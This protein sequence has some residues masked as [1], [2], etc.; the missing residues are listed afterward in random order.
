MAPLNSPHRKSYGSRIVAENNEN[1]VP[2]TLWRCPVNALYYTET[3]L[4][5]CQRSWVSR[6][7]PNR[8]RKAEEPSLRRVISVSRD[9][10]ADLETSSKANTRKAASADSWFARDIE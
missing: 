4:T 3:R 10:L 7:S 9:R 6:M 1:S 2:G 8:F 5:G